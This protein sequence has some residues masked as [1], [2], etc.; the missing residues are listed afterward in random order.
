MHARLRT[1]ALTSITF[2]VARSPVPMA[3]SSTAPPAASKPPPPSP[4]Q[5][6]MVPY[7]G[8]GFDNDILTAKAYRKDLEPW[9]ARRKD[10]ADFSRAVLCRVGITL[11]F[12]KARQSVEPVTERVADALWAL[13]RA[14]IVRAMTTRALTAKSI[15][16]FRRTTRKRTPTRTKRSTSSSWSSSSTTTSTASSRPS[17]RWR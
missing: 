10:D 15:D 12:I 17:S 1:C 11:E 13:F 6:I 4:V 2:R 16:S 5:P 3:S 7:A 8:P 14:E 9:I